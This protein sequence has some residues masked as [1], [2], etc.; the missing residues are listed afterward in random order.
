MK[1]SRLNKEIEG[2]NKVQRYLNEKNIVFFIKEHK[3][4]IPYEINEKK[5]QI[6]IQIL[7]EN[8]IVARSL[9]IKR[10]LVKDE[11]YCD[12]LKELLINMHE[13]PEITFDIDYDGNIYASADMRLDIIDYDNFYS[14]FYSIPFGIKKFIEKIAPKYNLKIL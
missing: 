6:T 3:I 9:I 11:I 1:I 5:F 7:G 13:T 10:E 14:G 4:Y 12:L 2:F 8:W